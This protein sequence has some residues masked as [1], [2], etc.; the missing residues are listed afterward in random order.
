M[1]SLMNI[2]FPLIS[3]GIDPNESANVQRRAAATPIGRIN[4]KYSFWFD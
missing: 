4:A 2:G 3:S 1:C